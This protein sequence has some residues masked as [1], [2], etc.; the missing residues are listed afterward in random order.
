MSDVFLIEHNLHIIKME[1]L[2][3]VFVLIPILVLA[4]AATSV[5][6]E[7]KGMIEEYSNKVIDQIMEAVPYIT[8]FVN[9]IAGKEVMDSDSIKDFVKQVQ[10][11]TIRFINA[12]SGP[13]MSLA[14]KISSRVTE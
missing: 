4:M 14:L 8:K 12:I 9:G 3:M 6:G 10:D 11:P 5:N 13:I 1:T 7:E 2:N